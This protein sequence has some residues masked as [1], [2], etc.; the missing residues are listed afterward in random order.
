[1]LC[2]QEEAGTAVPQIT[3]LR[4]LT[5]AGNK[6]RELDA[7]G[8]AGGGHLSASS[9]GEEEGM[10]RHEALHSA[11]MHQQASVMK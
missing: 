6:T 10:W 3:L 1:M 11:D 9:S 5:D 7:Q 4:H 8:T 2:V